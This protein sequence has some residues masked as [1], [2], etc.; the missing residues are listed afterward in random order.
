MF[1]D[2]AALIAAAGDMEGED[3]IYAASV[4]WSM[5]RETR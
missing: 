4:L 3:E 2:D 5:E 1:A